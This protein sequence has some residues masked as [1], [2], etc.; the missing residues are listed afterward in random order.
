MQSD[1]KPNAKGPACGSQVA[2]GVG[3]GGERRHGMLG[4]A[5]CEAATEPTGSHRF[6]EPYRGTRGE[7]AVA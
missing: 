7:S 6:E 3:Y 5:K 4:G 1:A 2:S